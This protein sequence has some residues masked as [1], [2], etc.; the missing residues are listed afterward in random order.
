MIC[1]HLPK[2]Y[3]KKFPNIT[4]QVF[5]NAESFYCEFWK[6]GSWLVNEQSLVLLYPSHLR[7]QVC[8]IAGFIGSL[9]L[10]VWILWI[11]HEELQRDLTLSLI[12]M[13]FLQNIFHV[14][15]LQGVEKEKTT[16]E[17]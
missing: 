16:K 10:F 15:P 1:A 11:F 4:H 9:Q 6:S 5:L 17:T 14:P 7:E 2:N 12:D 3:H 8:E 13:E